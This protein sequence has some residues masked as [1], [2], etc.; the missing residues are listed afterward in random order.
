MKQQDRKLTIAVLV[1]II[2]IIILLFVPTGF[3][4]ALIYQG[5]ERV[6]ARVLS[7]DESA[8]RSSGMIQFGEQTAQ[9]E[10]L[11]GKFKGQRAQGVNMLQGSLD[12]DKIFAPG[13]RALVVISYNGDEILNVTMIDHYRIPLQ[14]LLAAAFAVLL[15]AFA[16]KAGIRAIISFVMTVLAIWKLLVP[17]L[18]HG[19]NP[20]LIGMMITIGLTVLIIA[21]VY[22]FD[23]RCMAASCGAV[24]GII[25][26]AVMGIIFTGLFKIHGAVM[27]FSQSLLYS[28][29]EYLNLTEIFKA[30]IFIGASGAVMDLAVDITSSIAEVVSK[31]PDIS[32]MEAMKS[33]LNVGKATMGTMTTTLLLAY[34]G[35]YVMLLMTFMAQGTPIYNLLNYRTVSAEILNTLVG[36]FGLVTVAPFTALTAGVLL[37]RGKSG[38]LSRDLEYH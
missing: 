26:T 7:T 23:R 5:S 14:L 34:S 16:G 31:V 6:P 8:I 35:S 20:I 27:D 15:I 30:A 28:G 11:R 22:G 1:G 17:G 38:K 36:S 9:V 18:L 29:F 21:L 33:G 4:D 3:E 24:L 25:T 37:T 12:S 10:I 32:W 13:D 2:A 19:L